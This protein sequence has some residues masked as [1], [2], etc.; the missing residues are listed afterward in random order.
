MQLARRYQNKGVQNSQELNVKKYEEVIA[1]NKEGWEKTI[2]EE[3]ER[4]M[5]MNVW[6]P[7]D[8][9]LDLKIREEWNTEGMILQTRIWANREYI[10][11]V[12][13]SMHR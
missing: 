3:N 11:T 6:E 13:W 12:P 10:M 4:M 2:D 7:V 5:E 8:N 9:N 1:K